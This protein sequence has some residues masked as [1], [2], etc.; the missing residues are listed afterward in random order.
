MQNIHSYVVQKITVNLKIY[1]CTAFVEHAIILQKQCIF[2]LGVNLT[3]TYNLNFSL[4]IDS[5]VII[6]RKFLLLKFHIDKAGIWKKL[7][8]L[9]NSCAT[10]E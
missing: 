7:I 9:L 1:P 4:I 2:I 5:S 6:S 3:V 10:T 8:R